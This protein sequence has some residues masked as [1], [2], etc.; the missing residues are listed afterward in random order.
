MQPQMQLITTGNPLAT[1]WQQDSSC[2][3]ET[4]PGYFDQWFEYAAN[5]L[6]PAA[7]LAQNLF[8]ILDRD[9]DFV[10]RQIEPTAY[11]NVA[12]DASILVG[13][14]RFKDSYGNALDDDLVTHEV[15]GPIFPEL[16]LPAGSRFFFDFDNTQN[17]FT[18]QVAIIM[19]GCKRFKLSQ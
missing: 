6:V 15:H 18:T 7:S 5:F 8:I 10:F 12:G 3:E 9:A 13:A 2:P 1:R 4:P 19:R 16:V 11:Q 17:A 14:F